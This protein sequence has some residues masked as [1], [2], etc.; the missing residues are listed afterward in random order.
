MG[1]FGKPE[2]HVGELERTV[3]Y[4]K[5]LAGTYVAEPEDAG[6]LRKIL[7]L[8]IPGNPVGIRCNQEV[9]EGD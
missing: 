1:T 6:N 9:S 2:K 7:D 5:E 3:P 4:L 8:N